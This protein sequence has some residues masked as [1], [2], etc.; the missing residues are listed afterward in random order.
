MPEFLSNPVVRIAI[1]TIGAAAVSAGSYLI[2]KKHGAAEIVERLI[3]ETKNNETT[4]EK[5]TN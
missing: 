4:T 5:Q 3:A 2:G 1:V